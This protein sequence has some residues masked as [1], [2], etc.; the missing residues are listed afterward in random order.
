[1]VEGMVASIPGGGGVVDL[2][3]DTDL[4]VRQKAAPLHQF[5]LSL[6]TA[7][8]A[9]ARSRLKFSH[10]RLPAKHSNLRLLLRSHSLV[11]AYVCKT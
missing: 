3:D 5:E 2:T 8:Q 11:L 9:K 10:F 1:M 6:Q 4:E 7:D